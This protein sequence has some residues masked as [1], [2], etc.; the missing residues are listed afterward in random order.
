VQ[1]YADAPTRAQQRVQAE[2]DSA[3]QARQRTICNAFQFWSVCSDRRCQRGQ[4][5]SGD[6]E[7]CFKRWWWVLPEEARVFFRAGIKAR[8]AGLSVEEAYREA[9]AE[10]ARSAEHIA[11]VDAETLARLRAGQPAPHGK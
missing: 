10:V 9:D 2:W 1:A 5:C 7:A 11:R 6:A 8:H 4:S 3:H